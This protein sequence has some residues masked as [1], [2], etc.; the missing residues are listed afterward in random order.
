[1]LQQKENSTFKLPTAKLYSTINFFHLPN[2]I[3]QKKKK[4]KIASDNHEIKYLKNI[5]LLRYNNLV[6]I[7]LKKIGKLVI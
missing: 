5:S 3:A 6:V 1:M 2:K 4:K 7:F